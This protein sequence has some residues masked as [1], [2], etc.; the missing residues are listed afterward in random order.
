[1]LT[2]W[3][4]KEEAIKTTNILYDDNNNNSSTFHSHNKHMFWWSCDLMHDVTLIDWKSLSYM[5]M[6]IMFSM[7]QKQNNDKHVVKMWFLHT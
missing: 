2:I 6:A 5:V 1:M 7:T 3:E 4:R